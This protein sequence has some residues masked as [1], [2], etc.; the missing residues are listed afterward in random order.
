MRQELNETWACTWLVDHGYTEDGDPILRDCGAPS[1]VL[2]TEDGAERGYECDAGH[3]HVYA[4]HR[5]N[6]GW[7]YADSP[8]E[9]ARLRKNGVDAVSMRGDSI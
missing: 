4:E 2:V 9:A 7:D 6:E 5:A 1:R 8:E 3:S